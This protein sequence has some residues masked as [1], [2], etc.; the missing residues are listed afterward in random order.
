MLILVG[1]VFMSIAIVGK[2]LKL[3]SINK[4][5]QLIKAILL[6]LLFL[7]T[8]EIVL[9]VFLADP[10]NKASI[11]DLLKKESK[12]NSSDEQLVFK[13]LDREGRKLM[14]IMI[15]LKIIKHK[16]TL[17]Y[18]RSLP[19]MKGLEIDESYGLICI[20]PKKN[21]FIVRVKEIDN[22]E[23]R[24][25]ASPEILNGYDDVRISRSEDNSN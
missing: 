3:L 2:F 15:K 17:N 19:G 16:P 23:E 8:G 21:L 1:L 6:I 12:V 20:S 14:P 11:F 10:F 18:V 24:K 7:I 4:K 9:E 13:Y 5:G 22:L 25:K